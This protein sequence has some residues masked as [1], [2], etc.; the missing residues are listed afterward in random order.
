MNERPGRPEW[1]HLIDLPD[2]PAEIEHVLGLISDQLSAASRVGY[3]MYGFPSETAVFIR[4]LLREEL[5]KKGACWKAVYGLEEFNPIF[6]QYVEP[7]RLLSAIE[8]ITSGLDN[9]ATWGAI[10]VE[11]VK[12]AMLELSWWRAQQDVEWA[13]TERKRQVKLA[14]K[15]HTDSKAA[16]GSRHTGNQVIRS[17]AVETYKAFRRSD[18]T[19]PR[20][21]ICKRMMNEIWKEAGRLGLSFSG[22][23]FEKTVYDW[24]T[25]FENSCTRADAHG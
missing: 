18:S 3:S 5:I 8:C 23:R 15:R 10:S 2:E 9:P 17:Y 4:E 14:L 6:L 11:R 19:A 21:A 7:Q 16:A 12:S 25:K 20:S 13:K 24:I 1:V 22:D